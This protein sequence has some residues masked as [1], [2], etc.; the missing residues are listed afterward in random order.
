MILN[1]KLFVIVINLSDC[2]FIFIYENN[3]LKKS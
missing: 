2:P 3:F 1:L